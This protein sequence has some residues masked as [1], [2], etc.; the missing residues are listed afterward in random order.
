ME[1]SVMSSSERRLSALD[2]SYLY[3]ESDT[4]PLHVGAVLIFEG[5]IPFGT[6]VKSIEQR[7]HLVPRF[8]QR[9]AAVPFDLAFPSWENDP[10]FQLE[11]HLKRF[12]LPPATNRQE[13]IRRALR[14]YHLMLDR[15][16][17]L[18]EFLCFEHWPGNHTALVCKFH[19]A[20]ADGA[21][22][23]RLIKRLFDFSSEAL[24]PAAPPNETQTV[25]SASP[26]QRL[27]SAARDLVIGQVRSFTELMVETFQNPGAFGERNRRLQEAIGKIAG[28]P[29]RRIVSTPWNTLGL[30]GVRDL[31]WFRR[32]FRDYRAIRNSFGGST[33]DVLHRRCRTLSQTSRIFDRWILSYCLPSQCPSK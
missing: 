22:G 4:N 29:G 9:L 1:A 8:R 13:A 26:S 21:S 15:E 7:L 14:E 12:E 3:N 5:H 24:L 17:P 18:W 33:D 11:N 25:Q 27:A 10:D 6:V 19:H 23:V 31:V 32:S 2:A 20:L 30:S 16:R 28:P